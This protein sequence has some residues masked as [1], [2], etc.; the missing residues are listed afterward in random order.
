MD[1]INWEWYLMYPKGSSLL[2]RSQSL[3]PVQ[4]AV[5]DRTKHV[6]EES[7]PVLP[8]VQGAGL[9]LAAQRG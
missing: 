4:T 5:C 8:F 2:L 3:S 6:S 7:E 1:R 9:D